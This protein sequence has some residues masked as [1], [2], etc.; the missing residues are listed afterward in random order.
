MKNWGFLLLLSS[1]LFAGWIIPQDVTPLQ[2]GSLTAAQQSQQLLGAYH[3]DYDTYIGA[4]WWIVPSA[5][6]T[7]YQ[8]NLGLH[9]AF[10][11]RQSASLLL[12][13]T[14]EKTDQKIGLG[15]WTER[16]GIQH[17]DFL[18]FPP[19]SDYGLVRSI[20]T[21]G[22]FY[23]DVSQKLGGGLGMQWLHDEYRGLGLGKAQ[24]HLTWFGLLR[25]H[26][27]GISTQMAG[28]QLR[29]LDARLE[30]ASRAVHGEDSTG[31]KTYLP[32]ISGSY[33]NSDS[34]EYAGKIRQNVYRQK[35]F[36]QAYAT[37][38]SRN[39]Q[40]LELAGYSDA[41][42]LVGFALGV[43]AESH[44]LYWGGWL[45]M[46]FLRIGYNSIE[47]HQELF[48]AK[49]TWTVQL[50]LSLSAIAQKAVM[51]WDAPQSTELVV[52]KSDRQKK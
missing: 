34:W 23:G 37:H 22:A 7:Q 38:K 44:E 51:H 15:W 40:G 28:L 11:F 46:P 24:D 48:G 47:D 3:P 27:L 12:Q 20:N 16:Q 35:L 19:Y 30:F 45:E 41:S 43:Y 18:L 8:S 21:F 1:P 5:K 29:R 31:W 25:F 39:L 6:T 10:A 26:E 33:W 50:R 42:Q 17:E 4:N 9:H 14:V 2:Q 32:D 49:D 13:N 52:Q 36:V